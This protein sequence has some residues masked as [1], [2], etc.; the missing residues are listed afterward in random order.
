[1]ASMV[2]WL[3]RCL[4]IEIVTLLQAYL[5]FGIVNRPKKNSNSTQLIQGFGADKTFRAGWSGAWQEAEF[6]LKFESMFEPLQ[7]LIWQLLPKAFQKMI[8][9][10]DL[11]N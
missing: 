11:K 5:N 4:N 3:V 2:L 8:E 1:M 6:N 10:F 7:Q 9:G